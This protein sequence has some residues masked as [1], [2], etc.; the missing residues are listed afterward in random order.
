MYLNFRFP[1]FQNF[2]EQDQQDWESE[3]RLF[4]VRREVADSKEGFEYIYS[5]I[6]ILGRKFNKSA[7]ELNSRLLGKF[8]KLDSWLYIICLIIFRT[9]GKKMKWRILETES[10]DQKI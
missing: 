8:P 10:N 2:L 1:T 7:F 9:C 3:E 4:S 6:F 5:Y